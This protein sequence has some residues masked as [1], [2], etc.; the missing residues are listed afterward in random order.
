MVQVKNIDELTSSDENYFAFVETTSQEIQVSYLAPDGRAEYEDYEAYSHPAGTVI[1]FHKLPEFGFTP[2]S[3]RVTD[4]DNATFLLQWV[5]YEDTFEAWENLPMDPHS[6][7]SFMK[8]KDLRTDHK[9]RV[10][11]V[12][13]RC[14]SQMYGPMIAYF[15]KDGV[16]P[17]S[18][19]LSVVKNYNAALF[20]P[21]V[22][23]SGTAHITVLNFRGIDM[24][25][26]NWPIVTLSAKT[27]SGCLRQVVEWRDLY[28][29]GLSEEQVAE[30]ANSFINELGITEQMIADLK[31]SEVPM[32]VERFMR[33]YGTP[34]HGFS[35]TGV[36]PQS[37][38]NHLK[39]QLVYRT[40]SMLEAQHPLH[41][42]IDAN[43]KQQE[44]QKQQT[45]ILDF[46][47]QVMPAGT[48]IDEVTTESI[49]QE[50]FKQR[51]KKEPDGR[52][53]IHPL[54]MGITEKAVLAARFFDGTQQ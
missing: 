54:N 35:E 1:K 52:G 23:I 46:V 31:Q 20:R 43:I 18:M 8:S 53:P 45:A 42:Q 5:N 24:T 6:F 34:R 41:P 48:N 21:V 17:T 19:D 12:N 50:V 27:L 10:L 22:N 32:P 44:L 2:W 38:K 16:K 51:Y 4:S 28:V 36:L 40:L 33:G 14:D 11:D 39:K 3:I 26:R 15:P 30:D 7:L 29:A 25:W 9:G 13:R 47:Y 37:L 49:Y